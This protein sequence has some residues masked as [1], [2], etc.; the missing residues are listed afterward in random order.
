MAIQEYQVIVTEAAENDLEEILEYYKEQISDQSAINLKIDII[1]AINELKQMPER[2]GAVKE[3][4]KDGVILLRRVMVRKKYQV[5]FRI[6]TEGQKVFVLRIL[7]VK[8]SSNFVK[9]ALE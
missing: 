3:A 2:H 6:Q 4:I 5:I 8:R 1:Q 7:H 9:K